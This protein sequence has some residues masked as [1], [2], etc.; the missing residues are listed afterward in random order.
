[1]CENGQMVARKKSE[2]KMSDQHLQK[3]QIYLIV[4]V[5]MC[6]VTTEFSKDLSLTQTLKLP[7]QLQT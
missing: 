3:I 5:L 1:V 2:E 4:V 7:P 6:V